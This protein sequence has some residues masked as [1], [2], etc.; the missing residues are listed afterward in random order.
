[1]KMF[2][3]N[4]ESTQVFCSGDEEGGSNA[5]RKVKREVSKSNVVAINLST[6]LYLTP[7]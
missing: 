4:E 3:R 2:D 7:F 1:M 6:Y 5:V